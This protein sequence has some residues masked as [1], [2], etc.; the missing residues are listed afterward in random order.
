MVTFLISLIIIVLFA[1]SPLWC[2]EVDHLLVKQELQESYSGIETYEADFIQHNY[3]PELDTSLESKGKIYYNNTNLKLEYSDPEGQFL[4]LDGLIVTM[5]EPSSN[6]A[7]ISAGSEIDLRPGTLISRYWQDSLLVSCEEAG[8]AVLVVMKTEA[9]EKVHFL[10]ENKLIIELAYSDLDSN[11]V[12]YE[13]QE[14]KL[15]QDLPG[16]VFEVILPDD[17]NLIDT[18]E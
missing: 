1:V 17:V 10:I 18:R 3:W 8:E 16:G 12:T 9:G 5:Y 2:E 15:N 4:L 13:F 7:I 6:Q 11:R 14:E